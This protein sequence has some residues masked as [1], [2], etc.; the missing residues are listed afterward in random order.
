MPAVRAFLLGSCLALPA[1]AQDLTVFAAASLKNALDEVAAAWSAET[2]GTATVSYAGSSALARQI[3][4]GAP[5]DVFVSANADWMDLLEADGLIAPGTRFGL[6]GNELVVVAPAGSAPIGIG[7]LPKALGGE[8]LA[9]AFVDAVPAGIYGREALS[10]LG[11]WDAVADRVAQADNVRSALA[12]V[13][14]AE[15]PYGIVYATDAAAEPRV[16]VVATFPAES[17]PDIVYSAAAVVEGDLAM[18]RRFL[19]FLRGA[20]ASATFLRHGF[21]VR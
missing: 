12:L 7:D 17:Q 5:A 20:E 15:A 2:G 9:M 4:A 1:A 13:A 3:E 10:S 19:D 14:T 21:T 18:A 6:L 16:S 8:R 11:L